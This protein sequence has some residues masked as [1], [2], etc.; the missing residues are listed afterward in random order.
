MKIKKTSKT[1][2]R[3][4][5]VLLL[6]LILSMLLPINSL[7]SVDWSLFDTWETKPDTNNYGFGAKAVTVGDNIYLFGGYRQETS[8][9]RFEVYNLTTNT[10]TDKPAMP[11]D[12]RYHGVEEV[13]GKIYVFGGQKTDVAVTDEMYCYDIK[14]DSWS[15]KAKMLKPN[16]SFASGVIDGKI[17]VAGGWNGEYSNSLEMYDPKTD[18]WTR[19]AD[20]PTKRSSLSGT[21][22]NGK[23]YTFG[24]WNSSAEK[25][26]NVVEVYD[27]KTNKWETKTNMPTARISMAVAEYQEN[28]YVIGGDNEDRTLGDIVECYDTIADKWVRLS[29]AP[30][31]RYNSAVAVK[32]SS[33]YVIDGS[34]GGTP[35][36]KT[37]MYH[38]PNRAYISCLIANRDKTTRDIERARF[39]LNK[40]EESPAKQSM[41]E[42]IDNI[43]PVDL[44]SSNLKSSSSM[45]D[46]YI[47]SKNNLS[48]SLDTNVVSFEDV[49]GTEDSEMLKAIG[50]HVQS[51]L[52]YSLE[53]SMPTN[54]KNKENTISVNKALL[55]I[56]ESSQVSYKTFENNT[57]YL[58]LL[59]N[60]PA[61]VL[62]KHYVDIKLNAG[63]INKADIYKTTLQFKITQK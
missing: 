8:T 48:V 51:S 34:L 33:I 29:N 44:E 6:V 41:Q 23:L 58:M 26:L 54:I 2:G 5:Y 46:I 53:V 35:Y 43:K 40:L 37:E 16:R 3:K 13:D 52:P 31:A 24:G 9:T 60:Q 63:I 1:M 59:D 15:T 62:N 27:P 19:L 25:Y 20:M 47:K 18:T 38:A 17:Y 11:Y 36:K 4:S 12:A 14:T 10:W 22:S 21:S 55:S 56:R 28:I 50:I 57:D 7:A 61:G 45:S 39:E 32:D 49:D 42:L 30:T